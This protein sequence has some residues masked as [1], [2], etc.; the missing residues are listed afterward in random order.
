MAWRGNGISVSQ[1]VGV[2]KIKNKPVL[3]TGRFIVGV[4]WHKRGRSGQRQAAQ[5]YVYGRRFMVLAVKEK[6]VPMIGWSGRF[7][8]FCW[9]VVKAK[10]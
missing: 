10:R 9:L 8:A 4:F 2:T 7:Y 3:G 5:S 6:S 1:E